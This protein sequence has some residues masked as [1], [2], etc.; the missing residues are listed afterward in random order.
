MLSPTSQRHQSNLDRVTAPMPKSKK[1]IL[2]LPIVLV[3]MMGSGKSSVGRKLASRLALPFTDSDH[4]I[5]HAAGC[6][7]SEFFARY[8]EAEFRAGERRV[9]AR[10]LEKPMQVISVGGGA[11]VQDDT[12]DV[13]QERAVSVWLKVDPKVLAER[14]SRR[15]D[16]PLLQGYSDP[17]TAVQTILDQR[18]PLYADAHVMVPSGTQPI[19]ETV[20]R[21]IA[22]LAD[23]ATTVERGPMKRLV[24]S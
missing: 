18:E 16:R 4:E 6:T 21:V 10:L 12:R 2:A 19:E 24:I 1:S 23:Y 13:I 11:F 8:G 5:E 3:G 17:L 7:I 15:N 14:V 22:A 20:E 9:I